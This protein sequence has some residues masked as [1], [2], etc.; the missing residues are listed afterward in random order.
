MFYLIES[1]LIVFKLLKIFGVCESWMHLLGLI[2]HECHQAITIPMTSV[3]QRTKLS[4][5]FVSC[6]KVK[7]A[8]S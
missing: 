5:N 6:M 4:L 3:S 1:L 8:T 2:D 7:L